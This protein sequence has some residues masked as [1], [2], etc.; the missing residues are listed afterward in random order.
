MAVFWLGVGSLA[1]LMTNCSPVKQSQLE[2]RAAQTGPSLL[3]L[4]QGCRLGRGE[5]LETDKCPFS[6]AWAPSKEHWGWMGVGTLVS[7]MQG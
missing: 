6:Q 2:P 4:E 7:C 1:L 5:A 3:A